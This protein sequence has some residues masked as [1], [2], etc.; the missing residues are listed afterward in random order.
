MSWEEERRKR[1]FVFCTNVRISGSRLKFFAIKV[2]SEVEG[3]GTQGLSPSL[4]G[5]RCLDSDLQSE[6]SRVRVEK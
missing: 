2:G 5:F 3:P 6:G 4:N 1:D